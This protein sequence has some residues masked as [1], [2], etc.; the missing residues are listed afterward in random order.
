MDDALIGSTLGRYRVVARLGEG[1]MATV[2][3]GH[4]P[5]VDRAVALKVV[6][7]DLAA[8]PT[9]VARFLREAHA[10]ARL[11]HPHILALYDFGEQGTRAFLVMPYVDGGTLADWLRRPHTPGEVVALLR[12][13]AAALDHAHRQGI[14]HRDVKPSNILLVADG[15]PLLA[16]FGIAR[17]S[18]DAALTRTGAGAGTPAYMAPEQITGRPL[19]GRADLYALGVILYEALVGRSPFPPRDDETPF[20]VAFRQATTAPVA[21]R[22]AN[23]ALA[24]ALEAVL[25]RALATE[26]AGRYPDGARLSAALDAALAPAWPGGPTAPL[27]PTLATVPAGR[28]AHRGRGRRPGNGAIA[29]GVFLGLLLL[30]LACAGAVAVAARGPVGMGLQRPSPTV[31][32][33]VGAGA[34]APLP[35]AAPTATATPTR[36]P[37][38]ALPAPTTTPLPMAVPPATATIAPTATALPTATPRPQPTVTPVPPPTAVPPVAPVAPAPAAGQAETP[39][40]ATAR[41][42]I[43]GLPGKSSG[44]FA[45]LTTG[46]TF[47]DD[48]GMI[49][50][51]GAFIDLAIAGA[52]EERLADGRWHATDR[53]A[54][55]AAARTEGTGILKDQPVGTTYTVDQLVEIMLAQ[56]D[57]TAANLLIDRLGGFGPANDFA[58]RLGL[59]D[60]ALR[61]R[62]FDQAAQ[63]RGIE[64]TTTTGDIAA[65]FLRLGAGQ[66]VNKAVSDRLLGILIA[67]AQRDRDWILRALPAGTG[68]AHLTMTMTGARADGGYIVAGEQLY[69]LVLFVQDKDEAGIERA[70]AQASAD[71]YRAAGGR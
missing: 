46:E 57:N 24:P 60:T 51:A 41:R 55:T 17:V 67:R 16:D 10:V 58:A 13:I 34:V 19:D 49:M 12:P 23:P 5:A 28:G 63:A 68:A 69:V 70:L 14:V 1:G 4:D 48:P 47:A 18:G 22:V 40:V 65:Y 8:D 36:A 71:I 7:A 15:T 9:F 35:G 3:R 27:P 50:P 66:V 61:R 25:L 26:P 6:R 43:L 53:V 56:S 44:V 21:P 39:L 29:V 37:Q 30:G 31:P 2:Y 32:A 33:P 45:S 11:Q 59:R 62:L 64:N 54:L 38:Q 52:A 20:A 42:A